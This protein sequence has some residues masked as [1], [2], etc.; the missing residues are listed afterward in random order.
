MT[1]KLPS[2]PIHLFVFGTL[3]HGHALHGA[4]DGAGYLG[5]YRTAERFPM[6]VAGSHF[7]PMMLDE[8]GTGFRIKGELYEINDCRLMRIDRLESIG[9]P[10]HIR[11]EIDVESL[12]NGAQTRAWVY[13][14]DRSLA[15]PAHSGY[16]DDY[17]D[18]R[19]IGPVIDRPGGARNRFAAVTFH[20]ACAASCMFKA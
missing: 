6:L 15:V 18:N 14:K 7:A 4:L 10:G 5:G 17:Q 16:L 13:M 3:K 8:P 1:Q 20:N 9:R 12:D 2:D 11:K 19:F